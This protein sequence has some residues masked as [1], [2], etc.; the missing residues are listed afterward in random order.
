MLVPAVG[1]ITVEY[2]ESTAVSGMSNDSSLSAHTSS[3]VQIN[4]CNHDLGIL[5]ELDVLDD[6]LLDAQQGAP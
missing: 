5:V 1:H 3:A 2:S 4:M 6:R